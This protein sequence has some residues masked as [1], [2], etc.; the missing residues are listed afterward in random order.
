MFELKWNKDDLKCWKSKWEL[1][2]LQNAYFQVMM[3]NYLPCVPCWRLAARRVLGQGSPESLSLSHFLSWNSGEELWI[4]RA[5]FNL[6]A[7]WSV[8]LRPWINTIPQTQP[9]RN[10]LF[11]SW[12]P[13]SSQEQIHNKGEEMELHFPWGKLK[14][15]L[16]WFETN[17]IKRMKYSPYQV[18]LTKMKCF[19]SGLSPPNPS[20]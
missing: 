3:L 13:R 17:P 12:A 20:K 6:P 18:K 14:R 8:Q 19:I 4:I 15:I 7:L 16:N 11:A 1:K 9:A 5:A 2:L 10:L